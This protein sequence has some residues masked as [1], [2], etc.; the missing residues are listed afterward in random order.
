[1]EEMAG[2]FYGMRLYL[3]KFG[4]VTAH[5]GLGHSMCHLY[6][7]EKR[8]RRV[9]DPVEYQSLRAA[10]NQYCIGTHGDVILD[11][12]APC[13]SE[14][15]RTRLPSAIL[16]EVF[17]NISG[18]RVQGA[19]DTL[20]DSSTLVFDVDSDLD[21]YGFMAREEEA[22]ETVG[23]DVKAVASPVLPIE[24]PKAL[25][26]AERCAKLRRVSPSAAQRCPW[27]SAAIMANLPS[28]SGAYAV[29]AQLIHDAVRPA[30]QD[31]KAHK[32]M[33]GVFSGLIT[34]NW[35]QVATICSRV[36]D[37]SLCRSF[38]VGCHDAHAHPALAVPA[39]RAL[40]TLEPHVCVV[41]DERKR[42]GS[43]RARSHM[44]VSRRQASRQHRHRW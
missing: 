42:S 2:T 16:R 21:I 14:R 43:T 35:S 12:G 15:P 25:S 5:K 10:V 31:V 40:R 6:A 38:Y 18:N 29:E 44:A 3:K 33:R 13:T 39:R 23:T 8:L 27:R 1:M 17:Q 20:C 22:Q 32:G 19:R 11:P 24:A 9:D 26:F 30:A 4:D 41:Q 28:S 34:H 37:M 7:G 36:V